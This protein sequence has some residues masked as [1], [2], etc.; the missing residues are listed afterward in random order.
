MNPGVGAIPAMQ[1]P[2][3]DIGHCMLFMS[4]RTLFR[5]IIQFITSKRTYKAE[6]YPSFSQYL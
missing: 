3:I 6:G 5:I 2:P 1:G 4:V